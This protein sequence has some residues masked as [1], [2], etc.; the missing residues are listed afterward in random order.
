SQRTACLEW[1]SFGDLELRRVSEALS[2]LQMGDRIT[3]RKQEVTTNWWVYMPPQGDRA[4]MDR[5]ANEL[6]DLG[7]TDLIKI[8]ETGR[9]RYAISLGAFRNE[10]GA[11]AYLALLKEQGVRT[12]GVGRREQQMMQTTLVIR[13]PSPAESTKL[14]E[15]A[16]RFP[17][18]QMRAAQC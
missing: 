2:S 16:T 15:L 8:T 3:A 12:G 10:E 17:G 11:R 13:S 9:W 4:G 1:G 5:K 18:S 7:I 14:V 6:V